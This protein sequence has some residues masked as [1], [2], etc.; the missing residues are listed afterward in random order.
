MAFG[1]TPQNGNTWLALLINSAAV[2]ALVAGTTLLSRLPRLIRTWK[3]FGF[4]VASF[5]V[6][7]LFY[8]IGIGAPAGSAIGAFS[9]LLPHFA[10]P[11]NATIALAFLVGLV[12]LISVFKSESIQKPLA[13]CRKAAFW[14]KADDSTQL[15]VIFSSR[16]SRYFLRGMRPLIIAGAVALCLLV[17]YQIV[18]RKNQPSRLTQKEQDTA[19]KAYL[20]TTDLATV[21][22]NSPAWQAASN[23]L[24]ETERLI[25][26]HPPLWPLV[27]SG[28]AFLYLWWLS[29]L[30][31]DLAFV[32]QKYIRDASTLKPFAE[33]MA[34][35]ETP[36]N[37]P[38][39]PEEIGSASSNP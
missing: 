13:F 28:L 19:M 31:F 33:C 23:H 15:P 37:G 20:K 34:F 21:S 27:L 17:G 30:I 2:A 36:G 6:G 22:P 5:A 18:E 3:W 16:R 38:P 29:A 35:R 8:R 24:K 11:V 32:W 1:T 9:G 25:E 14:R 12:G 4:G 39:I 7:A 26:V 10:G